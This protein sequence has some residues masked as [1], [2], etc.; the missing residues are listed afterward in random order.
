MAAVGKI[1]IDRSLCKE[2]EL[3]MSVCPEKAIII[4]AEMNY[5]GYHPAE[6]KNKTCRGCGLCAIMCPEIAIEVYRER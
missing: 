5:K 4:S 6:F 1:E 3:C 2:C